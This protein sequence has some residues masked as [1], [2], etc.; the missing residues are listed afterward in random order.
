MA[1]K[2]PMISLHAVNEEREDRASTVEI[3]GEK[4]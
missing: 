1:E 3:V 2:V 4:L